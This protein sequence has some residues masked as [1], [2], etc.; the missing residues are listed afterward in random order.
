MDPRGGKRQAGGFLE[1]GRYEAG[2]RMGRAERGESLY[3]YPE[4]NDARNRASG[5]VHNG[6]VARGTS[7]VGE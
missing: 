7:R 5:P 2:N 3:P 1:R 6:C 4:M